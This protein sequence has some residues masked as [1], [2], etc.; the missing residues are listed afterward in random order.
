MPQDQVDVHILVLFHVLLVVVLLVGAV[1]LV[2]QCYIWP[3]LLIVVVDLVLCADDLAG[4]RC[5]LTLPICDEAAGVEAVLVE[6]HLGDRLCLVQIELTGHLDHRR[7][8]HRHRMGSG[9]FLSFVD[10]GRDVR[11]GLHQLQ[12]IDAALGT[13]STGETRAHLSLLTDL[14]VLSDAHVVW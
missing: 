4:A 12:V 1:I 3:A 14:C 5:Q 6:L 7:L 13:R 9:H 2:L 8:L 11:R 10:A